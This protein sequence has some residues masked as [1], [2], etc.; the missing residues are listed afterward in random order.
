MCFIYSCPYFHFFVYE[1]LYCLFIAAFVP[2]HSFDYYVSPSFL[3]VFLSPSAV[4]LPYFV[5]PRFWPPN[6]FFSIIVFLICSSLSFLSSFSFFFCFLF[7]YSLFIFPPS[8]LFMHPFPF[9]LHTLLFHR[10]FRPRVTLA[11]NRTESPH[12]Y[13]YSDYSQQPIIRIWYF[14]RKSS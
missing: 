10:A 7:V 2:V 13:T 12:S 8:C 1:L 6:L 3:V 5:L 11:L 14:Y 4:S 9:S